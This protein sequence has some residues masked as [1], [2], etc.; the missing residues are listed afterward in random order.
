MS[1]QSILTTILGALALTLVVVVTVAVTVHVVVPH[2]SG[3]DAQRAAEQRWQEQMF[4][5]NPK[6]TGGFQ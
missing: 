3:A 2:D 5:R 1:L 6:M 4:P